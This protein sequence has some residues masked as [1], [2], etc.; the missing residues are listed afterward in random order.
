MPIIAPFDYS[1]KITSVQTI[2][3]PFWIP[4]KS[5]E[6]TFPDLQ[7][8]MIRNDLWLI[9][10]ANLV[11]GPLTSQLEFVVD[12]IQ[13]SDDEYLDELTEGHAN[14]YHK[15]KMKTTIVSNVIHIP[16]K[17]R[18]TAELGT[19][20]WKEQLHE[21]GRGAGQYMQNTLRQINA[22]IDYYCSL[23]SVNRNATEVRRV[24]SYETMVRVV[25]NIEKDGL[26]YSF[27]ISFSP[28]LRMA[29][30][31]FP[32]YRVRDDEKLVSFRETLKNLDAPSFHQLQWIKTLN[33]EREHRYQEALLSASL[34]LESLVYEYI[35]AKGLS[36]SR[37]KKIGMEKW[38]M[39]QVDL[40]KDYVSQIPDFPHPVDYWSGVT[41][42][43]T[44]RIWRLRNDVVH[45]QRI[46]TQ[47]DYN[48][49]RNDII[50][51]GNL[52]AC[53]LHYINPE[54]LVLEDKF[55]S[56]LEHVEFSHEPQDYPGQL[57][58]LKYEWRRELDNY[59][60]PIKP[61][62]DTYKR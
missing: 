36:K 3:L 34:A 47:N 11:D 51:L 43:G 39:E 55:Q 16:P 49:I 61:A 25:M 21:L 17:G 32:L 10:V 33:H 40:V 19:E 30:L 7:K 15:R 58:T 27:P 4:I 46:L 45:Q 8:I 1:H 52:R 6:Y 29:N 62:N 22:F 59:Q 35:A 38:V 41:C 42:S 54:L 50:N 56:F 12:E 18:I 37:L 57:L 20:S 53:F 26:H 48:S 28:D 24:S 13:V 44:A 31:P 23:I 14:Y 9:S 2:E 60:S 5:G